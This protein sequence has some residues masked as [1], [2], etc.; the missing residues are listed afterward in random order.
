MAEAPVEYKRRVAEN[1][2]ARTDYSR[3]DI[4]ARLA[5]RL[6]RLAAP[7]PGERVLDIA[8]GTGFVAIPTA[9]LVG[10]RG[11][12]VGVDI[13]S[14]M[15][16]QASKAV[17]AEGLSNVD[18]VLADA[19]TLSCPADS[20]D[21]VVCAS[22]LPYMVDVPAALRHWHTIL[23]PGGRLAFNCWS[24]QSWA[25]NRLLRAVA[26]RHGIRVAMVGGDTGT[27]DRCRAVLAAARFVRP[28][29]VAEPTRD[30]FAVEQL[31]G[32]LESAPKNPLCGITPGDAVRLGNLR[33][34]Y[35]AEVSA[36]STRQ[37]I[38]TEVGAYFVLAYK[39]HAM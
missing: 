8:T 16:E 34:E 2:D 9:R 12:V 7:Q 17:A 22:A 25:T 35:A 4:H 28:E 23:R 15:L 21:L 18:L 32:V 1:F 20:F 38:N 14:G 26:A 36:A 10:E 29:I 27:P 24:E 3:S 39:P 19:E 13:S 11:T 31:E 33:D 6:I 30:Y 37:G 5:D